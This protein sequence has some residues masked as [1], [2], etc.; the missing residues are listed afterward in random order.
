MYGLG[1]MLAKYGLGMPVAPQ[2]P[3][4]QP[5]MPQGMPQGAPMG[6]PQGMPM[7]Q[8]PMGL[9]GFVGNPQNMF[10]MNAS[11]GG[12]QKERGNRP[13]RVKVYEKGEPTPEEAARQ[14]QSNARNQAYRDY[15]TAY[16]DYHTSVPEARRRM[17]AGEISREEYNAIRAE[18]EKRML[19]L[20]EA[21]S[22]MDDTREYIEPK[23]REGV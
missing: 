15:K 23:P 5:M 9:G 12:E 7:Q 11:A 4:Q 22:A 16:D 6:M 20:G 10:A 13:W 3:M 8:Q 21:Y 2:Q 1:G 18:K 19:E 14:A 17:E